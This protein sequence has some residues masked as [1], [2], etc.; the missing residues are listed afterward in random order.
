M[1]SPVVNNR[2]G[3]RRHGQWIQRSL[4][5][6]P[7]RT[8]GRAVDEHAAGRA[9]PGVQQRRDESVLLGRSDV[10]KICWK[11]VTAIFLSLTVENKFVKEITQTA[12]ELE[13]EPI[14][15]D[16]LIYERDRDDNGVYGF[17]LCTVN[18]KTGEEND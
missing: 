17:N 1:F 18:L 15:N 6:R 5:H 12:P 14:G 4:H 8:R 7:R 16:T 13:P 3:V 10:G 11:R 2:C 9:R